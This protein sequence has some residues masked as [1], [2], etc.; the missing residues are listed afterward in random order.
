[1]KGLTLLSK[2]WSEVK[3]RGND[4]MADFLGTCVGR[5]KIQLK[6]R[7]PYRQI[8]CHRPWARRLES[9]PNT[10]ARLAG[11]RKVTRQVWFSAPYRM[12]ALTGAAQLASWWNF[13]LLLYSKC[14]KPSV[15]S[16]VTQG[17]HGWY[18]SRPMPS[19]WPQQPG[20]TPVVR[21]YTTYFS[22][23]IL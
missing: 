16:Y 21:R 5:Q 15:M 22:L 19:L 13:Q 23:V 8:R 11:W 7:T 20:R 18:S 12:V 4:I 14:T 10:A 9:W 2:I 17:R 6:Y 1:M 3:Q